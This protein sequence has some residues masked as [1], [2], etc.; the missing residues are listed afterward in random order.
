MI[1]TNF[2]GT[3]I[4][5]IPEDWEKKN[6]GEEVELCYGKGLPKKNRI[7]G[8]YPVFG[9]NGIVGSHN[10]FLV[11]GPGIIIGRKGSVGEVKFS[12]NN[13]WPIDTTYYLKVKIFGII[14]S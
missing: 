13:F 12:K 9:S 10:E 5:M 6:L 14:F 8:P 4:G 7:P 2:K 11:E 3:E 1:Q